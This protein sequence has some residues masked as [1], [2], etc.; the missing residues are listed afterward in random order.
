V[1]KRT[2]NN[3]Q[4]L[5]RRRLV[6]AWWLGGCAVALEMEKQGDRAKYIAISRW[7]SQPACRQL[8]RRLLAAGGIDG[9]MAW[10]D[11]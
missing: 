4:Q 3:K 6:A 10:M 8:A 2:N 1:A 9:S 5:Q 11:G 7:A